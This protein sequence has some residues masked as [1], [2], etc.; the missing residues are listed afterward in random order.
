MEIKDVLKK[1]NFKFKKSLGQNFITDG[2]MLKAIILDAEITSDDT[3]VEIGT[4][5][6]SLTAYLAKTAKRV[7]TFEVDNELEPILKETLSECKN[8]ETVFCDVLRMSDEE[9]RKRVPEKFKVVANLPY[10]ITTPLI[11]RFVESTLEPISMTLMMQKEVAERITAEHNTE[12]YGAITVSI[13]AV[14]DARITR[15][16]DRR[17]FYPVP[18]VDSALVKIDFRRDKYEFADFGTF[19]KVIKSAFLM[20]RKTLANN[21]VSAFGISKADCETAIENSGFEK[22]VRGEALSCD[23]FVKIADYL[24]L[25]CLKK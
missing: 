4:G 18:N 6:G 1:N 25:N 24:T 17:L 21:L 9:F 14:A 13:A 23:D 22:N 19:K 11:M 7:V 15:T 5:A 12:A 8:V 3:V 20:R 2:N 16:I 10:Y